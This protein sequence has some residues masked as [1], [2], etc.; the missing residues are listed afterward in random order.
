MI[1]KGLEN[2]DRFAK[3]AKKYFVIKI[4]ISTYPLKADNIIK[5]SYIFI[6]NA[7]SKIFA[8]KSI[9]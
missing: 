4:V 8:I 7:F 2:K 9:H 1:N 6:V 5:S 3:F